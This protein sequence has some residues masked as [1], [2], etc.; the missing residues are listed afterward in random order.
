MPTKGDQFYGYVTVWEGYPFY[1]Q[2][3]I[4]VQ[5]GS[6][7]VNGN[8]LAGVS[9][10]NINQTTPPVATGDTIILSNVAYLILEYNANHLDIEP[11]LL[12]N[13]SSGTIGNVISSSTPPTTFKV[14]EEVTVPIELDAQSNGDHA[15]GATN[16]VVTIAVG[17]PE[18]G[19]YLIVGANQYLISGYESNIITLKTGLLFAIPSG[20]SLT[21]TRKQLVLIE[22]LDG[23]IFANDPVRI[24]GQTYY[25][26]DYQETP[27][28]VL[29]ASPGAI[30]TIPA[31]STGI[32][33][34]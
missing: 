9:I 13:I 26:E 30:E 27:E 14:L 21:Q 3:G 2:A 22:D 18:I 33:Y 1:Q 5:Y 12:D 10:V 11:A 15:A 31:G 19:Q 24:N 25:I 6:C 34:H 7:T 20:T 8:H 17:I 16:I 29:L 23:E 28:A 4:P 32:I